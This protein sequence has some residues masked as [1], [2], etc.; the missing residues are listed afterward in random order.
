MPDQPARLP[1]SL[2]SRPIAHRALHGPDRPENSRPAIRAAIDAG[3]AIELDVQLSADGVAMV[4]HDDTLER[5]TDATGPLRDRRA[6]DLQQTTLK[7]STDQIPTLR[8]VLALVAGQV[9]LLIEIKDQTGTLS[10]GPETLEHAVAHDL[11]GYR[12]DV[13][14]MSFNPACVMALARH[15]PDRPRG[16]VTCAFTQADWPDLSEPQRAA[17]ADISA[18]DTAG[19]SFISHDWTDL[20]A[21]PVAQLVRRDVPVLCWTIRS[22]SDEHSARRIARNITFEDYLP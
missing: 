15:A 20:D 8:D 5:L 7:G 2:L 14:L 1:T 9:P 4:F 6:Q 21:A 10:P 17:L 11:A 13:A 3:Y 22:A 18:F 12:G 16:L 19:C